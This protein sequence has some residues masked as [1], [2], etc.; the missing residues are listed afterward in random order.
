MAIFTKAAEIA[1]DSPDVRVYLA[2]HYARGADWQRAV[3]PLER[4]LA[5][6]PDRFPAIEALARIRERQG[7]LPEAI[8]L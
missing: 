3:P 5:D 7:H 8:A 4:I 6:T 1:P 2:L